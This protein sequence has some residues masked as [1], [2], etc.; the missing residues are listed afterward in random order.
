MAVEMTED[1]RGYVARLP[2]YPEWGALHLHRDG[3]IIFTRRLYHSP[4]GEDFYQQAVTVLGGAWEPRKPRSA[5]LW[6]EEQIGLLV[7]TEPINF[8]KAPTS[9][10]WSAFLLNFHRE[11]KVYGKHVWLG[12]VSRYSTSV[13]PPTVQVWFDRVLSFTYGWTSPTEQHITA[14]YKELKGDHL[15]LERRSFGWNIRP[16]PSTPTL[17]QAANK[18]Y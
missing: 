11:Q 1:E 17:K 14:V 13:C 12:E 2:E 7:G 8:L 10:G 15:T 18:L 5:T 3:T 9:K 16:Y 4:V 6:L